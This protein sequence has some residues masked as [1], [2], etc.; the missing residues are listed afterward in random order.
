MDRLNDCQYGS[1]GERRPLRLAQCIDHD[2]PSRLGSF[3]YH[4]SYRNYRSCS[5]RNRPPYATGHFHL[6]S[7]RRPRLLALRCEILSSTQSGQTGSLFRIQAGHCLCC[8]GRCAPPTI[9]TDEHPQAA[10]R[11]TPHN[12]RTQQSITSASKLVPGLAADPE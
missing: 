7:G 6:R 9:A 12:Q 2:H 11:F 8:R 5:L 10:R 3:R 1:G 4:N